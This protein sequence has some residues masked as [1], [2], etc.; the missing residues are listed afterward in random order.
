[1]VDMLSFRIAKAI[2]RIEPEKTASLDVLKF[3]LEIV[4][5]TLFTISIVAIIGIISGKF[6]AAMLGLGAFIVL[7]YFSG[8]LH[9]QKAIHCSLIS[10]LAI[11]IAPHVPLTI[12]WIRII[13][14]VS[15][16]IVLIYAPSNIEGHA[17]IP[18]KYFP[19]L[20]IVSAILVAL[21]FLLLNSTVACVF[22]LQS[23]TTIRIQRR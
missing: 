3:S 6:M 8:G 10:I 13:G 19:F 15:L 18:K 21:N 20:K 11:S 23:I 7:R 14:V 22:L 17:R 5:N 9:M 4:I 16:A 12:E 2:K 1:M